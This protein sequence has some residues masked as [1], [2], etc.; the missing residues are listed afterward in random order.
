MFGVEIVVDAI[1]DG[2]DRSSLLQEA[3]A[4]GI[5]CCVY[6]HT[7]TRDQETTEV[8]LNSG[9]HTVLASQS[10]LKEAIEL[11][12]QPQDSADTASA[13]AEGEGRPRRFSDGDIKIDGAA[14]L[15]I[16]RRLSAE[17]V[18]DWPACAHWKVHRLMRQVALSL[19]DRTMSL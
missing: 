3:R 15:A 14:A 13:P 16:E 1:F 19:G 7:A 9:A 18:E 11:A 8:C 4:L 2:I 6:S 17:L 5:Y 10:A 12:S